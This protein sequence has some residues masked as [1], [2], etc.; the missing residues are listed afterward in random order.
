M[1][2]FKSWIELLVVCVALLKMLEPFPCSVTGDAMNFSK[3]IDTTRLCS[4]H[5]M[6]RRNAVRTN[7]MTI[8]HAD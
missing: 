3:S 7:N 4:F 8:L 5:L 1:V 6:S 2:F